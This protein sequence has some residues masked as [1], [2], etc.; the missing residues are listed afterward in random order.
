MQRHVIFYNGDMHRSQRIDRVT[1][2]RLNIKEAKH[3]MNN[4][5]TII[6]QSFFNNFNTIEL[7]N[8]FLTIK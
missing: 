8:A 4:F 7:F 2:A 3:L 5:S 1:N 6:K